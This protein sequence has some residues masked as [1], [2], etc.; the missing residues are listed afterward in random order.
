[1]KEKMPPLMAALWKFSRAPLLLYVV[2]FLGKGGVGGKPFFLGF[3]HYH[4]STLLNGTGTI[5]FDNFY[6][7]GL[8]L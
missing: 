7:E 5:F 4:C 3:P 8:I 2:S 1:M 6:Q